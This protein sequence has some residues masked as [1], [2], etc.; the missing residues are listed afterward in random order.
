MVCNPA[1]TAIS[2]AYRAPPMGWNSWNYFRCE[3]LNEDVVKGVA[4]ALV[5]T[6]LAAAGYVYVNLD[7]E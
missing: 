5:E 2:V 6:G 7:G 4:E 1:P 3:G